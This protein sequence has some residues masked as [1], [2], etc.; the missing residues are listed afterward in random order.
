M[1]H[2]AQL[3]DVD[4]ERL[5][6][7]APAAF[8]PASE[9]ERLAVALGAT[10]YMPATRRTLADDLIKQAGAG[11]LSTVLCLEDAISDGELAAA[12]ANVVTQLRLLAARTTPAAGPLVFIRVRECEQIPVIAAA[13][14]PDA[15]LLTGFV[16]PKFTDITGAAFLDA[17]DDTSARNGQRFFGMPV[18]ESPEVVHSETRQDTLTGIARLLAKHRDSVLAVRIG[19]TDMCAAFG[20]RRGRDHTIYDVHPVAAVIGD[21]V[22]VL[23]RADGTGFVVTGGVWEYFAT[24]PRL[25][26]PQLRTTPFTEHHVASLR[27][28]LL[29]RDLDGLI[30]EVVLDQANGLT[31]KTVIHPSHVAAVHA[32]SVVTHEEHSD[33][34]DVLRA[35]ASGGGVSASA[36]A[37]KMNEARPH[38]AWAQ[39]TLARADAFG[40][41]AEGVSVVDLLAAIA[42]SARHRT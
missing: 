4:L 10:L 35:D 38:R 16:L 11:V 28:D 12:S 23:G 37:N 42:A 20:I 5:F 26:K 25:F 8:G 13:L 9:R 17:L 30:R 7:H 41:A 21:V 24:T 32:L 6:A 1:R 36:Y 14:G 34:V 3:P 18:I 2:F 19:A 29:T 27:A 22:N 40:V 31:G 33:A 39:R 15:R